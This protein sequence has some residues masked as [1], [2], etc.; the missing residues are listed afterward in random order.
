MSLINMLLIA[1]GLAADAFAVSVAEGIVISEKSASRHTLRVSAMFGGFQAV[2]PVLGWGAGS[3]LR[4]LVGGFDHWVAFALLTLIGG[5]MILDAALGIETG[6]TAGGSR[7]FKLIGLGAATSI[8]AFAVGVTIAMLRV[9]IWAPAVVIGLVTAVLC[10]VGVQVGDRTGTRLGR[11]AE[12]VGG[13]VLVG[14]AAKVL[15][16]HL[17]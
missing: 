11:G 12:V 13:L 2:M 16:E 17:T 14:L 9:S 3:S 8:D 5:K 1:F 6:R 10:A 7:G 15:L 4:A